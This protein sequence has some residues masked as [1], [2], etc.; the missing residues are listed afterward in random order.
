M[1]ASDVG[2]ADGTDDDAGTAARH[3]VELTLRRYTGVAAVV[4]LLMTVIVVAPT[5]SSQ[6]T[7]FSTSF[8]VTPTLTPVTVPGPVETTG[9]PTTTSLVPT[10]TSTTTS[11]TTTVPPTSTTTS[12]STTTSTSSTTTSTTTTLLPCALP[13]ACP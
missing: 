3:I 5:R 9:V 12:S 6:P 7:A 1:T 4:F 2:L 11:A 10:R 8:D 13:V